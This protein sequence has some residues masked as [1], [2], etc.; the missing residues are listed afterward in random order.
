MGQL[1]HQRDDS[2]DSGADIEVVVAIDAPMEKAKDVIPT[3]DSGPLVKQMEN[4][5]RKP[6]PDFHKCP[7]VPSLG[8]VPFDE[9]IQRKIR[10]S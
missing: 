1:L 4:P 9:A 6:E 8:E 2:F 7:D 5:I 3:H 10:P